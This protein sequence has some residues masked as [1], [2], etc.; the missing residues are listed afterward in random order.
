MMVNLPE[1]ERDRARQPVQAC[2]GKEAS[3]TEAASAGSGAST[4]QRDN[5]KD[6][7][8]IRAGSLVLASDG[9]G[10]GWYEADVAEVLY[11]E[12]FKPHWYQWPDFVHSVTDIALLHPQHQFV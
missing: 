9:P 11:E 6:W 5:P 2:G 1:S 8:R 10:D 3:R 12:K 4:V 7:P